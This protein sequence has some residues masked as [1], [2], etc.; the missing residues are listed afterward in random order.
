M[1][2]ERLALIGQV[3]EQI[4]EAHM[5]TCNYTSEKVAEGL[6]EYETLKSEGHVVCASE[7]TLYSTCA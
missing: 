5:T 1:N 2:D 4:I 7:Q 3:S 6:R